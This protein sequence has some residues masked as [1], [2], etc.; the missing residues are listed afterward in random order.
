[1]VESEVVERARWREI[2]LTVHRYNV[3][4]TFS[5]GHSPS[6]ERPRH[7]DLAEAEVM[8]PQMQLGGRVF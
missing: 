3:S 2:S 8:G 5:G 6:P 4:L 7:R 1:M